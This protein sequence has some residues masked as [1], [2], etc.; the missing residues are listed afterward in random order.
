LDET[1]KG[2]FG[3]IVLRLI[4]CADMLADMLSPITGYRSQVAICSW[5][6]AAWLPLQAADTSPPVVDP[7]TAAFFSS[8]TNPPA[9]ARILKIIHPWPDAPEAQDQVIHK[10]TGQGFGG[11]VCNVSFEKYLESEAK[12][13]AFTRAVAQ[14]RRAGMALWLYDERGYPSGNAGGLVL[15]DHPEW[16]A[17][18]L[19]IADLEAEAT[20]VTLRL[21]PGEPRLVA[22]FPLSSQRINTAEKVDLQ[23]QV[24]NGELT[25]STPPG[26][27]LVMAVTENR[28]FE[29][30]HA[31]MNL[32]EKMPYINLLQAEPTARFLELTHDRY[33]AHLDRDLSKFFMATFTDEPSL[34]SLFLKRMPYRV[35]PWSANLP[36]EFKRR[37]GYDL[38]P[39]IPALIAEA[40]PHGARQRYDFW[41]TVGELVSENYFGQIQNWCHRHQTL[42]GGHLLMEEDLTAH[43]PLYGDFFRCLRRL[44]APSIDCL[45]SLPAEVPWFIARLASSAAE[46][47]GKTVVMSEA[48]DHSQHWRGPGDNR[49]ARIVT[50]T[51]IRGAVNRQMA[52][53]INC[54]TSYY[55]F[56]GLEDSALQRLNEWIGRC[57]VM[58]RGGFQVADIALLYPIESLWPQFTPARQGPTDSPAA[59][60]IENIYRAA[61]DSLFYAQR[62]FTFVD[63]RAVIEAR[64]NA[65][66][67]MLGS[68]SW[69]VIVLPGVDTLPWAAWEKLNQFVQAGGVVIALGSRP[70]N[71]ESEFPSPRVQVLAKAMFGE[72]STQPQVTVSKAGGA[73]IFLPAGSEGLLPNLLDGVLEPDV[74][75]GQKRSPLRTTHRRIDNHEVFFVINDSSQPWSG[76]VAFSAAGNGEQWDPASGRI[77]SFA[78]TSPNTK[79]ALEAYGA[80]LFRFP[81]AHPP[82]RLSITPGA[83]PNQT[84]RSLPETK[85]ALV[86][87]EFVR[88]ELIANPASA[89]TSEATWQATG[90]LTKSD[91]DTFMFACLPYAPALDLSDADC[92]V[93]DTW[94]PAGQ[95][96]PTQILV[97]LQE[98]DGGDFLASTGRSLAGEG[99]DRIYLPLNRFQFAAW[100]KDADGQLDLRRIKEIR[101]GWG[102]YLGTQGEKVQFS[103]ALPQR[104]GG[105]VRI[106]NQ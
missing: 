73:G 9:D 15:R 97:I 101:I 94:I 77:R 22:A 75:V 91:V 35:L 32:A 92:L 5:I 87:G 19:L 96:A 63:S 29:G 17:H 34:M 85:P 55:T 80:L 71:S 48:S 4:S 41:L 76:E 16:E 104:L 21:P 53:G 46:L 78:D 102:G 56:S 69:R 18:G 44:D 67:L 88:A 8:F 52:S 11:V 24:R 47:E 26:R 86:H 14:A 3:W 38:E 50:E 59:A 43:V 54:F 12:W 13:K 49:P 1:V 81:E 60:R 90:W 6:L 61:A 103:F 65:Q 40:G 105:K 25:W 31:A 39:I 99:H 93:L 33:A 2:A 68:L 7:N 42:S 100:S 28:L 27:W 82:K 83:L 45:T 36:G 70:A 57:C 10:L 62:D 64:T 20:N 106:S 74:K 37:R 98:Q 84:K 72:S 95:R 58:L 79:L 30:T 89:T 23:K 51:E 66:S